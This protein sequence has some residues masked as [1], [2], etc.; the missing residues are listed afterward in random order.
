MGQT[1]KNHKFLYKI[2]D[3]I[4]ILILKTSKKWDGTSQKKSKQ[5]KRAIGSIVMILINVKFSLRQEKT[6]L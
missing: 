2:W 4:L 1:H 6:A 3:D 5:K